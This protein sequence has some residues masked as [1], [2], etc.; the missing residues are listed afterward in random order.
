M[1]GHGLCAADVMRR[2][3]TWAAL[4]V[5][6]TCSGGVMAAESSGPT[7]GVIPAMT[8]AGMPDA[9]TGM[10]L[11]ALDPGVRI[12]GEKRSDNAAGPAGSSWIVARSTQHPPEQH[13]DRAVVNIEAPAGSKAFSIVVAGLSKLGFTVTGVAFV[14]LPG[15]PFGFRYLLTL[16][17]D[18]PILGLRVTDAIARDSRAGEGRALLIGAWKQVP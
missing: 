3:N 16:A 11:G 8:P 7:S 15:N 17:A 18:K 4:L 10:L 12:V 14:P 13:P 9:T 1:A 5:A 6:M 2:R